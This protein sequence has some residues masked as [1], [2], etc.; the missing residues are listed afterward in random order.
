MFSGTKIHGRLT[1]NHEWFRFSRHIPPAS[2]QFSKSDSYLM[3]LPS[4]RENHQETQNF[5]FFENFG[6][7][8]SL[9]TKSRGLECFSFCDFSRFWLSDPENLG[10]PWSG[11]GPRDAAF[12]VGVAYFI[13][14]FVP[15]LFHFAPKI[16]KIRLLV[17][18]NELIEDA[19]L[20]PKKSQNWKRVF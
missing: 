4:G 17:F 7:F 15:T 8:W 1:K 3:P 16:N 19:M 11:S 2:K 20:V 13:R 18:E 12:L 14:H 5:H 9:W 6:F 10:N